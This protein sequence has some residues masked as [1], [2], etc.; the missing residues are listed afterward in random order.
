M[1]I[2]WNLWI[3]EFK[4]VSIK[5]ESGQEPIIEPYAGEITADQHSAMYFVAEIAR[6]LLA[7]RSINSQFNPTKPLAILV[8]EE[9]LVRC[10]WTKSGKLIVIVEQETKRWRHAETPAEAMQRKR[11][12]TCTRAVYDA[13]PKRRSRLKGTEACDD[14]QTATD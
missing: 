2:E 10:K 1:K 8:E 6:C 3:D 7:G 4:G 13:C 5:G 9:K 12:F 11:V 14:E